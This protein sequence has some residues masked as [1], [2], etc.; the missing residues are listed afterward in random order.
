METHTF[1]GDI[2]PTLRI[3]ELVGDAKS[4][5]AWLKEHHNLELT[6]P[7][8]FNGYK[9]FL[10]CALSK[11]FSDITTEEELP[12]PHGVLLACARSHAYYP[13][14]KLPNSCERTIFL[15]E[16]LEYIKPISKAKSLSALEKS[17]RSFKTNVK[18]IFDEIFQK[19]YKLNPDNKI[20][21]EGALKIPLIDNL[22]IH[23]TQAFNNGP[24][25]YNGELLKD[26]WIPEDKLNSC[27]LGYKYTLQYMWYTVV[28]KK[29]FQESSLVNM[30]TADSWSEYKYL[31][32]PEGLS[33]M[34]LLIHGDRFKLEEQTSLDS[35]FHRIREEIVLPIEKEYNTSILSGGSLFIQ[36]K[37]IPKS[38]FKKL[39]K[40][41]KP[42]PYKSLE[43]KDKIDIILYWYSA[44]V[45]EPGEMHNGVPAFMTN[46]AGTVALMQKDREREFEKIQVARFIHEVEQGKHRYSYSIL[47]DTKAAADHYHSGWLI[48]Y[49]CCGD[50]SGF[51]GREFRNAEGLIQKYVKTGKVNLQTLE[52]SKEDF[53]KYLANHIHK[54]EFLTEQVIN[55][56]TKK[57]EELSKLQVAKTQNIFGDAK[58]IILELVTYYALSQYHG[59]NTKISWSLN[60]KNG[61]IDILVVTETVTKLIECKVNPNNC[62]LE[63][64][65][66]KGKQ[67]LT[68]VTDNK[69]KV[70]FA[71]ASL[72][73]PRAIKWLKENSI[74]YHYLFGNTDPSNIFKGIKIS[75]LKRILDYSLK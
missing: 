35:Y 16:V 25:A 39:L 71:F 47:I 45:F 73:N 44:E 3:F 70:E 4:Y 15:K 12:I 60:K 69:G 19:C 51:A 53:T 13:L 27:F 55:E 61:E 10:E 64:E 74:D 63:K 21:L 14:E 24:A 57:L 7:V 46:L 30:H 50:Y 17:I 59:P 29:L 66:Q 34:E 62:N 36:H 56:R 11:F 32:A 41:S 65:Y 6:D 38:I 20:D 49:D 54:N 33:E 23:F 8:L 67:K 9:F 5:Q 28:G 52:V 68:K 26:F 42:D 58:G 37:K 43:T 40:P 72:P 22:F 48:Y 2:I 18:N 1:A 31:P 75:N